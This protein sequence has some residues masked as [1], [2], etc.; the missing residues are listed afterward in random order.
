MKVVPQ[1]MQ[2]R[3]PRAL[4][5]K[6]L[7]YAKRLRTTDWLRPVSAQISA[8]VAPAARRPWTSLHGFVPGSL[9]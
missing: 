4:R 2:A 5:E 8:T 6:T 3:F 9:P 1:H 7:R